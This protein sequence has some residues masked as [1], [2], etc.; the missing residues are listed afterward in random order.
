[1]ENEIKKF[2]SLLSENKTCVYI[3]FS[4]NSLVINPIKDFIEKSQS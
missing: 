3:T 4:S 1:M 2:E